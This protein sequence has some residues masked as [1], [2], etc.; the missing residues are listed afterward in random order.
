MMNVCC[1]VLNLKNRLGVLNMVSNLCMMNV[2]YG[3][4]NLKGTLTMDT[5]REPLI[6]KSDTH[7][8]VVKST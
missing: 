5:N 2:C 4:L 8:K 7:P 1:G 3:V 6:S